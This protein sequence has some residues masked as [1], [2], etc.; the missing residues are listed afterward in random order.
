MCEYMKAILRTLMEQLA[1]RYSLRLS[2]KLKTGSESKTN[3][4]FMCKRGHCGSYVDKHADQTNHCPSGG[5]TLLALW[6]KRTLSVNLPQASEVGKLIVADAAGQASATQTI[7]AQE[8]K[9]NGVQKPSK[10][11]DVSGP[12]ALGACSVANSVAVYTS[13]WVEDHSMKLLLD[14]DC[15]TRM[16]HSLDTSYP[17]TESSLI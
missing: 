11:A 2:M 14:T 12:K 4:R 9:S 1:G 13:G 3:N 6:G 15:C 5:E 7:M 16:Y 8:S 10:S 17:R